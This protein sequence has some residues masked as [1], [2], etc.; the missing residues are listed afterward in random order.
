MKMALFLVDD[1]ATFRVQMDN[2]GANPGMMSTWI[3]NMVGKIS[4][5]SKRIKVQLLTFAMI[6]RT[7]MQSSFRC[8]LVQVRM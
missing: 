7:I 6:I 1:Y 5:Y 3:Q 4:R 8:H 2:R